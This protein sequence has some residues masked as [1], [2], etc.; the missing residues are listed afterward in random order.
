MAAHSVLLTA[1][2]LAFAG[3]QGET[4]R[5]DFG[6]ETS[7]VRPGFI[8]VTH[9]TVFGER[10]PVAGNGRPVGW[11]NPVGLVSGDL[12]LPRDWTVNASS[13][14]KVPPPIY[15]TDLRQDHVGGPGPALL[16]LRV[17]DGPYRLWLLCGT[18]GGS[19]D[20]V[21][22]LRAASGDGSDEATFHG[23]YTARVLELRG[24]AKGGLLNL[25]FSTRSRWAACA[26]LAVPE[27]EWARVQAG[28]IAKIEQEVFVLPDDVLKTWKHAPHE[29]PTPLP[30]FTEAEKQRGFAI[31]HRHY[32]SP[33]WPNTAPKRDECDPTLRAFAAQDE[34]EP[35]TFTIFPL[36]DCPRLSVEVSDLKTPDGKTIPREDISVRYVRY[37]HVRPNYSSSGVYYRAPDVLMPFRKPQPLVKGESFRVW[38][39]VYADAFAPEGIYNGQATVAADGQPPVPVPIVFR[40]LPIALEKDHSIVYGI[41]YYH[42]YDSMMRAPDAFSRQWW[43]RKAELEAADM[44]AH[45]NNA[46]VAGISGR[47]DAN[48]RWLLDFEPLAKKIDL[49]RRYGLDKP[50]ICHIPTEAAYAKYIKAGMGSHLRLLKMPPK[51]FFDDMTELVRAVEAGRK[52]RQWPELLY[53]PVDEPSTVELAVQ[54]MTEVLKAIKRVPGVRTYVTADPAHEQFAP[55]KPWVD[56]WCCQ[57]FSLSRETILDDMKKRGVEY[58]CYPNHINGENDHTPAAGARMTYG[59]GFWRSGFRALTPWIYQSSTSDPWNYLDGGYMDFFN[60]TDDDASPIPVALWEAY[61]EGIDDGRYVTTL[62]RWIERAREA[63]HADLAKAAEADLRFV[64][65]AI[66][67]QEKYKYDG[68]WDPEAFDAFRWLLARQILGLQEAV[69]RGN[70][71]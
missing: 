53:Y 43:R 26:L 29:E 7:P 10:E 66:E 9:K 64:W 18:A 23:A 63:G 60:R 13:G 19:R 20:Q 12:P 8:R 46:I 5:V 65:D 38:I 69:T 55:M 41:Y 28:E 14:R 39:T 61:R 50:I 33:I 40:V 21:W 2:L 62:E 22:D 36:R 31:Y 17:Q 27:A 44:A 16:R 68:L 48:G 24:E 56:V 32:L 59:F 54:F 51:E 71:K 4:V 35:L 11:V 3:A 57:P 49:C 58:W 70:A 6:T 1:T 25:A 34:Y 45:G 52:S 42:P 67:V 30:A 47:M 15:T 37:M